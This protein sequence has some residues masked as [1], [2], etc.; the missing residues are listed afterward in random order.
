[1]DYDKRIKTNEDKAS[2]LLSKNDDYQRL[3]DIPGIGKI[4]GR[5]F[6]GAVGD[7]KQFQNGRQVGAWL[8][9]TPKQHASGEQ[10]R[11]GGI[12]KRGNGA[13]RKQLIHGARAVIRFCEGKTDPLSIW[14]Q[15]LLKTKHKNKVVVALANKIARMAWAVLTTGESYNPVMVK[16]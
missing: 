7:G 6:I 5:G 15:R 2:E 4:V 14:L 12:S 10:S 16:K 3:Q 8:G 9:L 13:L 1:L 11:M